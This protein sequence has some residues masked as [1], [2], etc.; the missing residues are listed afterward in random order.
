[1]KSL[2]FYNKKEKKRQQKRKKRFGGFPLD[3]S[4]WNEFKYHEL[5]ENVRQKDN[6]K[7]SS[8]LNRIRIGIPNIGD[9]NS[10]ES[11][12]I[13]IKSDPISESARFMYEKKCIGQNLICLCSTIVKTEAI[14]ADQCYY[15]TRPYAKI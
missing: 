13:P 5:T 11:R 1:M 12:K 9:I 6:L 2:L 4:F 14:N 15:K 8:M 7:F 10:L 3:Y